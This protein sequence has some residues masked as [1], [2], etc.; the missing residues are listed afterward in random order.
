LGIK[1]A[2]L[3]FVRASECHL[4]LAV[5]AVVFFFMRNVYF[6]QLLKWCCVEEMQW[7]EK[8]SLIEIAVEFK[9]FLEAFDDVR[10][11]L[12][13]LMGKIQD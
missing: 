6:L 13:F 9:A 7:S 11:K 10:V 2:I 12:A 5:V 3:S 4:K 1:K 8:C